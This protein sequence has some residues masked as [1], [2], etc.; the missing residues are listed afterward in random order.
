[1][2]ELEINSI[3]AVDVEE[4]NQ[5]TE[6][7]VCATVGTN[8]GGANDKILTDEV[9]GINPEWKRPIKFPMNA[10]DSIC[11]MILGKMPTGYHTIVGEVHAPMKTFV[12]PKEEG[13]TRVFPV[14]NSSGDEIGGEL[15]ISYCFTEKS[16]VHQVANSVSVH[17]V[18]HLG[19]GGPL[20]HPGYMH[21][22]QQ[23]VY[24]LPAQ[25]QQVKRMSKF[26]AGLR[27]FGSRVGALM[28]VKM[29]S[30]AVLGG[31]DGGGFI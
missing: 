27:K 12:T 7:K 21:F 6:M 17:P 16:Y 19:Y 25:Q 26:M 14:Q 31:D 1:M 2:K 23:Q 5:S 8:G 13:D 9:V 29:V 4:I 15:H 10:T 28:C 22:P 20:Q 30:E 24:Y 3:R 11:L 18:A